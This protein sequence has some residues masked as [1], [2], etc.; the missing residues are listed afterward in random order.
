MFWWILL[1]TV[2]AVVA[3]VFF[4]T[5]YAR[6]FVSLG[7]LP[8]FW[9]LATDFLMFAC[10][11]F[12]ALVGGSQILRGKAPIGFFWLLASIVVVIAVVFVIVP[13]SRI[14]SS[15]KGHSD[16]GI[17]VFMMLLGPVVGVPLSLLTVR[18]WY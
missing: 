5:V 14:R 4:L 12:I 17:K 10:P 8:A 18:S 11:S 3:M 16:I 9:E 15:A 13:L 1:A 6:L 2:E 7:Q